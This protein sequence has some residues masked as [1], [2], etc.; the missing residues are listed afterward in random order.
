MYDIKALDDDIHIKCTGQSNK[1]IIDNIKYID[2][3]GANSEIRIP[4]IPGYN[5]GQ[6]DKIKEFVSKFKNVTKVRVLPYHNYAESKY[7]ALGMDNTLPEMPPNFD[8][9]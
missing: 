1:I 5:D 4:N 2:Q 8:F 9:E 6:I 3:S 7:T